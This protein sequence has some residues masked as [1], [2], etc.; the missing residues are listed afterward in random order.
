VPSLT[1]CWDRGVGGEQ[2]ALR[3]CL[4]HRRDKRW[5]PWGVFGDAND[6]S[7]YNAPDD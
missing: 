1:Q 3:E 7:K 2:A 4:A 6:D 5:G